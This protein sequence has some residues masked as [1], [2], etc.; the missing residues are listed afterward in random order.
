VHVDQLLAVIDTDLPNG[1]LRNKALQHFGIIVIREK[2]SAPARQARCNGMDFSQA[3][4]THPA[5][6]ERL[7]GK[8]GWKRIAADGPVQIFHQ[9]RIIGFLAVIILMDVGKLCLCHDTP[10][11]Q[12]SDP[13]QILTKLILVNK[14]VYRNQE[15]KVGKNSM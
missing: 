5:G 13:R 11:K 15:V 3:A 9:I 7:I 14:R 6:K 2:N 12:Q 1:L 8:G 10:V 4:P